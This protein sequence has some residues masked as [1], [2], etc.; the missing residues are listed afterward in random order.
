MNN[1]S[2]LNHLFFKRNDG[3][4]EEWIQIAL[5]FVIIVAIIYKQRC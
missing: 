2:F 3:T 5:L 4:I 1:F